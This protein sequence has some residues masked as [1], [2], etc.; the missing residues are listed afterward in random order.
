MSAKGFVDTNILIYAASGAS[1]YP[2]KHGRAWEIID[3]AEF[4]ISTQVMAEFYVAAQRKKEG[5]IPLT[6]AE[7]KEWIDRLAL[8]EVIPVDLSIVQQGVAYS[9]RFDISYWDAALIAAAEKMDLPV[10]YT[11][12][13]NHGQLYGSVKVINP[14][15][16]I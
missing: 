8:A 6:E 14:F 5:R 7:A 1:R 16:A 4:A 2:A 12:D 15:K 13:L 11:E 3:S 10:L 9:Q